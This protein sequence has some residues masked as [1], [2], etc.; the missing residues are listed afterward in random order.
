[1]P[2]QEDP[3]PSC[4]HYADAAG[5]H[6]DMTTLRKFLFLL[7]CFVQINSKALVLLDTIRN[8]FILPSQLTQPE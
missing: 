8:I 6:N 5:I 2:R 1:M 7:S 4:G 3:V